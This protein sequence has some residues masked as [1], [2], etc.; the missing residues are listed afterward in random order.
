MIETMA[1]RNAAAATAR[2]LLG[3]AVD[4]VEP[5]RRGRNSR[6]FRVTAGG[7]HFALKR[8]PAPGADGRDRLGTEVEALHLMRKCGLEHVPHVVAADPARHCALLSWLDGEPVAAVA[9]SDIDMAGAFLA[10]L[11]A[12]RAHPAGRAFARAAAEACVCGRDA[13]TQIESRL[14]A[15]RRVAATEE[16][17][18][19]FLRLAFAPALATVLSRARNEMAAAGLDFTS[20]LPQEERSLVPADFGFHNC[21]RGTDGTLRFLDFEYFGWDDPVKLAADMLHHPGTPLA[22]AQRARLHEALLRVYGGERAFAARLQ[23]L[24]PLFGMRWVLILLNEFLPERWRQRVA[25]GETDPWTQ[26]K[27]RQLARARELLARLV[28]I[29]AE[30]AHG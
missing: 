30:T 24:Y 5:V 20:P 21:L 15:L 23:A 28:P 7:V 8:Y 11:H 27:A 9:G 2:D 19:K 29:G 16:E 6:V 3:R 17:L 13:E 14:D 1:E 4:A 10:A 25:A 18:E 26:A 12:M 22:P